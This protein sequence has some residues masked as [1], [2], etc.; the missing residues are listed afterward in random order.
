MTAIL[1]FHSN[2][3]RVVA[4]LG[5]EGVD[6]PT[7]AADDVGECGQGLEELHHRSEL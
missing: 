6:L 4:D 2:H 1:Q 5:R 7:P 3:Y